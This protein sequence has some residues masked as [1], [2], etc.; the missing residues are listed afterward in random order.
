MRGV[1]IRW[2]GGE[3][4]FLLTVELWRT[5]Q[6]YCDAGP[7]WILKRLMSSQWLVDDVIQPIRLGLE[8]GG[9]SDVEARRLVKFFVEDR[10]LRA[11]VI[12]AVKVI[13]HCLD[14]DEGDQSPGEAVAAAGPT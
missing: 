13:N 5:L 11:S 1:D 10:P 12:T 9:M 14:E 4:K 8:G 2:A 6:Q 3:H 7:E